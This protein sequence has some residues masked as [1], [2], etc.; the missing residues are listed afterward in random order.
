MLSMSKKNSL[1]KKMKI[2]EIINKIEKYLPVR[3]NEKNMFGEVFTPPNLINEMLDNLPNKVWTNPDLKWLDPACG[4]G[5]F[6]MI[7]YNRLMTGLDKQIINPDDR[8]RHILQNMLYMV[9]INPKNV[10][11]AYKIFGKNANIVCADFL[12]ERGIKKWSSQFKNINKF[13]IIIGNLPFNEETN[14]SNKKTVSLWPKFIYKSLDILNDKGYIAFIHPQNWRSPDNKLWKLLT[15]KQLLYI[16][17]YSPEDSKKLFGN[18]VHTK[19]DLYILHNVPVHSTTTIID[20]LGNKYD[21][22]L[23]KLPFLSNYNI[24]DFNNLISNTNNLEILYST[25]CSTNNSVENKNEKYKYPVI[26][27]ITADNNLQFRYTDDNTKCYINI[28]K[29]II[30]GGRYAYPYNDYEG[31]YGM[32]QNLFAIPITS[33]KHGDEIVKAMNTYK[34]K[35]LLNSTKWTTFGIDYKM[36]KHFKSDFFKY[37]LKNKNSDIS[38]KTVKNKNKV[39]KTHNI[40]NRK[41]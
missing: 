15:S 41:K 20:Q 24:K 39:R 18:V 33:K 13:D 14:E 28:P 40:T 8:S 3:N 35:S 6:F 12:S 17:I 32:T 2:N 30:N 21:L 16:H 7:V 23:N 34:F 27:S 9:E 22:K 19:V 1:I 4:I 11:V 5:N 29:V 38:I 37:F 10:R 36:F 31:K 26:K 25:L